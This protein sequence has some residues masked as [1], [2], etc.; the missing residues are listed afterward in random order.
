M[1]GGILSFN[2]LHS[3]LLGSIVPGTKVNIFIS[4]F[5]RFG[6]GLPPCLP[7]LHV[8]LLFCGGGVIRHSEP[9]QLLIRDWCGSGLSLPV[10]SWLSLPVRSWLSLPVPYHCLCAV[11]WEWLITACA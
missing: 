10:R 4:F 8:F 3:L 1:W 6:P 7:P 11:V 2:C 5:C 9:K